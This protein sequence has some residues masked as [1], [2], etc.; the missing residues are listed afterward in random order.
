MNRTKEKKI[1]PFEATALALALVVNKNDEVFRHAH[2]ILIRLL[3]K[4]LC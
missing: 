1:Y 4:W 2:S 3:R